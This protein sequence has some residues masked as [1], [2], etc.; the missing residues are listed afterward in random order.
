MNRTA[1]LIAKALRPSVT[2]RNFIDEVLPLLAADDPDF[3]AAKFLDAAGIG[4]GVLPS[5]ARNG[6]S[7]ADDPPAAPERRRIREGS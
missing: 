2:I 7:V 4:G 1:K 6:A 5:G 3:S